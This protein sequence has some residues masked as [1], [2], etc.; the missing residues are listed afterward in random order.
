MSIDFNP[1]DVDLTGSF[2]PLCATLGRTENESAAFYVVRTLI[3]RDN[4]WRPVRWTEIAEVIKSSMRLCEQL[5]KEAPSLDR[6]TNDMATNPFLRP[7][8]QALVD[9][10]Y[11]KWHG[12]EGEKNR[13]FELLEQGIERLR[14]WVR[15]KV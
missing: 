6:W 13:P 4:E 7:D 12:E 10:G 3:A 11:A 1:S 8:F 15:K 5:G 2:P 14:R 9:G